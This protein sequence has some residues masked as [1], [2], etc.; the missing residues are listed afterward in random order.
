MPL[1]SS[2][3]QQ[4][5]YLA[6]TV[7]GTIP[8][9]GNMRSLRVTG[10]TLDYGVTKDSSKEINATRT[11]SSAVP[12]DASASGGITAEISYQEFDILM[13]ATLQD[14]WTVFGTNGVGAAFSTTAGG[15]AVGTITASAATTGVNLWTLLQKGQW[16]RLVAPGDAN[17]DGK[18][19]RV[20][21]TVAP[22]ATV[23]TLDAGTPLVANAGTVAA[24]TIS[25]SRLT[26]GTTQSSFT[27]ERQNSD[28][29]QYMAYTGMTPSKMDVNVS[30]GAFSSIS[31][32]FMGK[33]ASRAAATQLPGT[34]VNSYAFDIH[35]GVA[36]ASCQLWEGGA[37]ITGTFV[38]SVSL[39]HDNSLRTQGAI[40]SLGAVGI[41]SGT[42]Q[43]S[44]KLSVYFA[45]GTLFDKFKANTNSSI[46]FSSVDGSG[47]GYVFTIPVANISTWKTNSSAKDQDMMVD[48]DFIG[49]R[50]AGNATAAL[51]KAIFIDRVGV[52]TT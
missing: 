44:G 51:Q 15:L 1:A 32:D 47:N 41:G 4:V 34:A 40:C 50:D 30:S 14:T 12:T 17:N 3:L 26:H 8:V 25:T 20:S 43:V 2:S 38:K 16:F 23:I 24:C 45:N 9:A 36:G 27:I 6:E 52:A 37:P 11:V 33:A 29:G 18:I 21:P 39:S 13:A 19:L 46:I 48:I 49:L 31:F 28:V 7:F 10:E 22:T 5:R 42:I 35:S